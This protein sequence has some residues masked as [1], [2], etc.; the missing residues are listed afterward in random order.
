LKFLEALRLRWRP[1]RIVDNE[2]GA[3]IYMYISTAPERSYWECEGWVFPPTQTRVGISLPGNLEGPTADA[4]RFYRG[5]GARFE[6]CL[7]RARPELDKAFE[8]WIGRR[9]EPN[10]WGDLVLSG[11]SVE[12]P[13]ATPPVWDVMFETTGDKWLAITIPFIGD[14]PGTAVV[15]T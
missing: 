15:D 7:T 11:F 9:L 2:F 13:G 3:L 10:L 1:P 4:R 6:D 12:D 14:I 5:L 8:T